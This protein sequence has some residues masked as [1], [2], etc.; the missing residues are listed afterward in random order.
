MH[1]EALRTI[2]RFAFNETIINPYAL[3]F[4]VCMGVL[5]L[6]VKRKHAIIPYIAT[7]CFITT[8]QRVVIAGLDFDMLRLLVIIGFIRIVTRREYR[9]ITINTLDK[10][11]VFYVVWGAMAYT[12]M[13]Q[14]TG[15]FINRL[16]WTYNILGMY[17][18][19]RIFV[20]NFQ[21]MRNA[22]KAAIFISIPICIAML[23]E[24][25][26]GR[27]F[28][29]ILGGVPEITFVRDGRL[30]SQGAFDHP[31]LA[32][33]FGAALLPLVIGLWRSKQ[34][35]IL[36]AAIGVTTATLITITSSSSGPVL[37]YL[38]GTGALFLWFLR[39]QLKLIMWCIAILL[40]LMQLAM[41]APIW[42]LVN[43]LTVFSGSTSNHRYRLIQ[44]T[45]DNFREWCLFGVETT[46]HWGWGLQDVTNM[47]VRVA[48]D[49]GLLGLILFLTIIVLC[50]HGLMKAVAE[51]HGPLQFFVWGIGASF[52]THIVSFY[53]VRYFGQIIFFWYLTLSFVATLNQATQPVPAKKLATHRKRLHKTKR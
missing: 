29:S 41:N 34:C 1:H 8:M 53:G 13:H 16:G 12:L 32:G 18:I 38:A 40:V 9:F 4:V 17:F 22:V 49:G 21:S 27:N 33:S 50:F 2:E 37:S 5:I 15:A 43:R 47:Y 3:A 19:G 35:G 52:F 42:A 31:I 11:I 6:V 44:A 51:K 28:L 20:N 25:F 46:A 48:I 39:R 7:A 10:T 24:Q 45:V 30:R 23:I 26:S 36:H 14:T